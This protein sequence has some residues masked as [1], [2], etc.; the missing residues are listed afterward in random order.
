MRTVKSAFAGALLAILVSWLVTS[1]VSAQLGSLV[2]SITSPTSGSTVSG[3]K[4]VTASVTVVGALTVGG[5]QFKL[6]GAN[7]GAED[8]ASPYS[9]PW[10]STKTSNGSHTLTAVGRSVLGVRWTSN[11][12]T[13]TVFNDTTPPTVSITAPANGAT[14]SGTTTVTAS[15]AD[16]VG[17]V[18]VQFRLDGANLS[19]EDMAAPYSVA[20]NTTAA[21]NGS[22]TLTAVARD[23]AGNTTTA[24]A[25][26]VTVSNDPTPPTVSITAPANGATASGTTTVTASASDNVGVA[27]VQFRLDGA[28]LSA[29]DMAA[30][31]SVAWNTTAA[32]NGS[33][34][35]TAVARD[36]AGNTTTA[37]AVTVTVSNDPTPPTVSITAPANGATASGTTTVTA[38][39][40]DNV[41]RWVQ[42]R[43]DGANLSAEDMAAPYSVAWNTTAASNGSHTLTAVARDAAGNTT[44]AAAVTVTVSNDPTPPTVSITAPANGATA[45]GTT[46]VTA[47]ASDNVG[48][49]GV[50]FRLDGANLGLEDTAAP[51]SASWDTTNASNG[52][53]TSDRPGPRRRRQHDDVGDSGRHGRQQPRK[54]DPYRGDHHCGL[55]DQGL[56]PELH[57]SAWWVERWLDRVQRRGFRAGNVELQ[58]HWR[59]LD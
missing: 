5:V 28:N 27:G 48:V 11:P 50:Q 7:L 37:A 34:T 15:A 53:H 26:T 33:H 40:S 52:S 29:E 45:S 16:N 12:V 31:Y 9:I 14:A 57:R 17:V 35:L 1:R 43:L 38:S 3:A 51:Y 6:D 36:A 42:F 25:V 55:L 24:A 39:A 20:W 21:S 19:A 23:A 30:P 54:Y 56:D 8:T 47:S 58:R 59:E 22:H 46:T 18:G 4:T 10:D 41:G 32:S 2:V 44:T 13:V 49:V